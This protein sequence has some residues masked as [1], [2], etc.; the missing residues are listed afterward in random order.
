METLKKR[1]LFWINNGV[2]KEI[3]KDTFKVILSSDPQNSNEGL[4][5]SHCENFNFDYLRNNNRR[6][7]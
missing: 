4:F 5:Y 7:K 2:L 3:E 1:V 6:R